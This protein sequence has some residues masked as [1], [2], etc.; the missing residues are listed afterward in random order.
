MTLK[1]E[2]KVPLLCD[3]FK[4]LNEPGWNFT[5]SMFICRMWV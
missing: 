5:E 3:F 2:V 4:K 1:P